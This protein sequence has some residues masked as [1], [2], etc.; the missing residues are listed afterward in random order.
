[1]DGWRRQW[2]RDAN[3]WEERRQ[4]WQTD[5]SWGHNQGGRSRGWNDGNHQ[6]GHNRGW[7]GWNN[8]GGDR[9]R[10]W[11]EW[12]TWDGWEDDGWQGRSGDQEASE[13]D[14]VQSTES[15]ALDGAI[16][17][18]SRLET[19]QRET[20]ELQ[21]IVGTT[22]LV[23]ALDTDL[24]GEFV[25]EYQATEGNQAAV[26]DEHFERQ[27]H[28][29]AAEPGSFDLDYFRNFRDFTDGY[30]QHN[31][32][33]KWFR[34][35]GEREEK[36]RVHMDNFGPM[37]VPICDHP[38]GMRWTFDTTRTK[39]WRWQEMVA[40]LDLESM[41][42]VV[43]GPQLEGLCA[44]AVAEAREKP[45]LIGCYLAKTDRYDH[46]RHHALGNDETYHIW[47]FV[48]SRNNGTRICLHPDFSSTKITSYQGDAPSDHEVPAS[49]K[50][51][52]SGP[53]T[54]KY[55]KNKGNQKTLRFDARRRS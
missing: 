6:E 44:A 45:C 40:Q 39:P 16:V 51:G 48:L 30:K 19:D 42:H 41:R 24:H 11:D 28:Y 14:A 29:I 36:V 13:H 43:E 10:G 15:G 25:A 23:Q 53:G 34:E 4:Q 52:T 33:L 17:P 21:H 50:G 38:K 27:Q 5:D 8:Q 7:Y 9:S 26:A 35:F 32:A 54:Y 18:Q 20:I 1:M 22:P 3:N 55:F 12:Q 37:Q 2:S 31:I 46:K 47:D 49:G